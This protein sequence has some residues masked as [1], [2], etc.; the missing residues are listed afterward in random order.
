M[1]IPLLRYLINLNFP[2]RCAHSHTV[3]DVTSN[4]ETTK[5]VEEYIKQAVLIN[6][7]QP[8]PAVEVVVVSRTLFPLEGLTVCV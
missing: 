2:A 3:P 7:S 4:P 8:F 1:P 5:F 6:T